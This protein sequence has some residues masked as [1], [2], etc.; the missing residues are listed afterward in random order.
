MACCGTSPPCRP[1]PSGTADPGGSLPRVDELTEPTN[2]YWAPVDPAAPNNAHAFMLEMIGSNKRVLELGPAAGAFTRALVAQGCRVV[3]IE[4]DV[5]A[6]AAVEPVAER[7]IVDDL[8][9]PRSVAAAIDDERFDVVLGGDVLEHLPDPLRVLRACRNALKPGGYVV[10]S[11]PNIAHADV[12]LQLLDGHFSYRE[13]GLLDR[14]HLHFFTLESIEGMLRDAGLLLTDLRRVTVPV[15]HT[16]QAVDPDG[17]S[18]E[19]LARALDDPE[20][21]TYQFV[22]RALVHDGDAELAHLASRAVALQTE[23]ERERALRV[24][25]E[26][27]LLDARDEVARLGPLLDEAVAHAQ[28]FEALSEARRVHIEAMQSTRSYRMLAPLRALFGR[29]G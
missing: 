25:A 1:T 22:V 28:G 7:V 17:V 12:K 2:L 8:S 10:L 23:L 27:E 13:K 19:V 21:E 11:M 3:C 9:D 14:T 6:A 29:R 16:E 20:A 24:L 26:S 18:P 15:F 5:D 4:R